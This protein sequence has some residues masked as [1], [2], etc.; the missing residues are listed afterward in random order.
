MLITNSNIFFTKFQQ[1][2]KKIH[3]KPYF[4]KVVP[5]VDEV[6]QVVK[7]N[8]A[9]VQIQSCGNS[10]RLLGCVRKTGL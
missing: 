8:I 2:L 9:K 5:V 4:S 10:N 7:V 6:A 3:E 1:K